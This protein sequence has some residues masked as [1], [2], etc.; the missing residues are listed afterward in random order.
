MKRFFWLISLILPSSALAQSVLPPRTE[1]VVLVTLD[2]M[3]WQELFGVG[4]TAGFRTVMPWRQ[5]PASRRWQA[6]QQRQALLPFIWGTVATQ[7]Q[8]YGNRTYGNAVHLA[9]HQRFSYP[10]YQEVLSGVADPHVHGNTPVD[11]PHRTVLDFLSQQPAYRGRVAAFAS[12]DVIGHIL[13]GASG[14]FPVNAGWQAAAG[15]GLTPGEQRLNAALLCCPRRFGGVRA[16]TLTFAYALEYLKRAQ[17]RVLYLAFGE[18]DEFAH[19]GHYAEYL[20]AAHQAD[21]CLSQL[22]AYLQATAQYRGKTTLLITTDHGR[23]LG[24][25]W[26]KHGLQVPGSGQTWLAVIGPDTPSTGEQRCRGYCSQNQVAPTLAALLGTVYPAPRRA[27]GILFS[28]LT[29]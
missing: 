9:N 12:W 28:V 22:W 3:R 16:D 4:L 21:H 25:W 6:Q 17:P 15:A 11:N 2:G 23:G 10:G 8:V 24:P 5:G 7:G 14:R 13:N 26:P 18:T 27:G 20:D 19:G 29:P 1:N